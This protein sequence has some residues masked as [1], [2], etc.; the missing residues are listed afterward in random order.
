MN[1]LKKNIILHNSIRFW[2]HYVLYM[3]LLLCAGNMFA[4]FTVVAIPAHETCSG[5]GALTLSV[6]NAGSDSSVNY[7]VYLLPNTT[8][9][10]FNS[11]GTS[12][13][14]LND[15]TYLV[16]ATQVIN[17]NTV[18]DEVEAVIQD[19]TTSLTFE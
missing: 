18:Q 15:G 5:N 2:W 16:V 10:I 8:T 9:A 11:S 19:Q 3:V 17:G 1:L 12:V 13:T 6:Q 14:G 7:K 4:Q